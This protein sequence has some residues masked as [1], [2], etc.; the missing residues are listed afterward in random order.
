MTTRGRRQPLVQKSP[1]VAAANPTG[2]R[3]TASQLNS[4]YC[5][6]PRDCDRLEDIVCA[7][8]RRTACARWPAGRLRDMGLRAPRPGRWPEAGRISAGCGPRTPSITSMSNHCLWPLKPSTT[9]LPLLL[10]SVPSR[11]KL[12][13]FLPPPGL[14]EVARR[15]SD[16]V[17]VRRTRATHVDLNFNRS[18]VEAD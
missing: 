2:S 11:M 18:E 5:N 7:C 16:I 6:A 1:P 15:R 10:A 13:A 8:W 4:D 14:G 3:L 9:S 17:E 12:Y